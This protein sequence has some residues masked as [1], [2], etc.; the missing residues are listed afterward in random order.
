MFQTKGAQEFFKN[1]ECIYKNSAVIPNPVILSQTAKALNAQ[2][3]KYEE[4]DNRIVT[5]GRLSILQKRQDLLLKAFAIVHNTHPELEL[6]IYGDGQDKNE[7]QSMIDEAGLGSCVTL[8]GRTDEVEK[9]IYNARAFV[10]TSDFEGIP[11]ALIEAMS[12]GVP[13]V[14]TDC[15][16]GGAALLIRDGENGY[17][18]PRGD[19][20][21]VADRLLEIIENRDIAE[22][23][24]ANSPRIAQDFSEAAIANMWENYFRE[25]AGG[26]NG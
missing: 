12:L 8:A 1:E 26:E 19:A 9:N 10:L 21:A 18:V 14:S 22:K 23:F 11:N 15:S 5:V 13:S 24:S 16:P 17:I 20:N 7:I 25:I 2:R 4:R 3:P 6:V